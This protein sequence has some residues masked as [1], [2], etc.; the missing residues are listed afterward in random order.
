MVM[1]AMR[2]LSSCAAPKSI[3]ILNVMSRLANIATP[4]RVG[5]FEE[6]DFRMPG[7]SYRPL[8][9]ATLTSVGIDKYVMTNDVNNAAIKVASVD[10]V[11]NK[12][13]F[14]NLRYRIYFVK[15]QY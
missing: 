9:L 12:I 7:T 2:N 1:A 15:Y 10:K 11:I 5:I 13:L 8:A 14:L 4:P 3:K 6:C